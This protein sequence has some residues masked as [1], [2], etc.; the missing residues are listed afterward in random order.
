MPII[1]AN[2]DAQTF[3]ADLNSLLRKHAGHLRAEELLAI[4]A[5]V[6]GQIMTFQN[7][8][9]FSQ[10]QL[11]EIVKRNMLLGNRAALETAKTSAMGPVQ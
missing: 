7:G 10:D 6:V 2:D 5:Q 9:A 1:P 8:R 11:M 4:S 3:Y